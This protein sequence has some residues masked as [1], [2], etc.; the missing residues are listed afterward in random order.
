MERMKKYILMI[1]LVCGL[2]YTEAFAYGNNPNAQS[3]SWGYQPIYNSN[4]SA[5]TY[6]FYSTS[7]Y[8]NSVRQS[9]SGSISLGSSG[10]LRTTLWDMT[11]EDDPI[12][13]VP[14]P[15]PVGDTP[16]CFMLLLAAGYMAFRVRSRR[17][18]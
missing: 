9:Q 17:K 16:W 7:P 12:G 2:C 11:D 3:Q 8:I 5:P 1:F 15:V 10:P 6:E 14:D 4:F 18:A 13:V